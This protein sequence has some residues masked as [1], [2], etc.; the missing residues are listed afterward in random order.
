MPVRLKLP[1]IINATELELIA[2]QGTRQGTS[3][4]CALP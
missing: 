1:F 4:Q 3:F 2:F